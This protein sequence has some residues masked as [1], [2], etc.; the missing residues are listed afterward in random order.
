MKI[1]IVT[2]QLHA[3]YGGVLQAYALQ[4]VLSRM[5]NDV[6]VIQLNKIVPA[7]KGIRAMRKFL[8][9][10]FRRYVLRHGGVE[11]FRERRINEEFPV[12]GVEFV[13]FFRQHIN[14][15]YI[16]SF[17]EILPSDYDAFV[18]GS[19]QVWRP[20]YNRSLMNSY[21]DFTWKDRGDF[22]IRALDAVEHKGHH[23]HVKPQGWDIRRV[24]YAVSFGFDC[25]E[26][27]KRQTA[28][29]SELAGRF[30]ALSFR[31]VSGVKSAEEHLGVKS[32]SVL[33]PTMLLS[34]EDYLS[35][36]GRREDSSHPF[37]RIGEERFEMPMGEYVETSV[38]HAG[39]FEYV[40]DRTAETEA[41]VAE[42][43]AGLAKP[44]RRF[45]PAS[46]RGRE[47]ISLRVQPS[48]ESW[49]SGI[50]GADFVLTD[51]F[52][53]CVFS[54]LF[55]KSF[56]V[57]GNPDRGLSRIVWLLGQFGLGDRLVGADGIPQKDINWEKVD[58]KLSELKEEAFGFLNNNL[59]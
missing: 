15:R 19:D 13:R 36:I 31:E 59:M 50:A 24:A 23:K 2:L 40:L 43:E 32:V 47:E 4:K 39:V 46:P 53:A 18:V 45:L 41:L 14:I 42:L 21:L 44:V 57:I 30:D 9:R 12:I 3:N 29:A 49:I 58:Y 5:G 26:Y 34:A 1:A 35:L 37:E 52:H 8:T 7:P 33:D 56:A 10:A 25:W 55:H 51:S 16:S 27:T 28:L 38:Q 54:I 17:D 6:E 48:V 11:I 20:K 22:G